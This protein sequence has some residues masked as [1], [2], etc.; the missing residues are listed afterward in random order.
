MT[1]NPRRFLWGLR[2]VNP[3]KDLYAMQKVKE[4]IMFRSGLYQMITNRRKQVDLLYYLK[5]LIFNTVEP[6][7]K[8]RIHLSLIMNTFVYD[9]KIYDSYTNL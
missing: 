9:I 6:P 2:E 4:T 8:L 3:L 1:E 7:F 5:F